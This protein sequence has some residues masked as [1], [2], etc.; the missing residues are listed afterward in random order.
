LFR[1]ESQTEFLAGGADLGWSGVLSNLVI[2]DVPGDHGSINTG[3]NLKILAGKIRE[4]LR[5]LA[6]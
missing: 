2:E 6:G 1:A 3:S 5:D 4:C